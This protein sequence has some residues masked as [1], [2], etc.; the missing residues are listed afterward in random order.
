MRNE[1]RLEDIGETKPI[2]SG[3]RRNLPKRMGTALAISIGR[4]VA[5]AVTVTPT[6]GSVPNRFARV[7]C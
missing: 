7:R 6:R 5:F 3:K 2:V 4:A 1:G